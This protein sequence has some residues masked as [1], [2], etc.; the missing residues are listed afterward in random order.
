MSNSGMVINNL[1]PSQRALNII[2]KHLVNDISDNDSIAAAKVTVG[3]I[4][5]ILKPTISFIGDYQFIYYQ[6]V[7]EELDRYLK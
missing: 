4:L 3:E 6:Q 1:T 7:K 2:E 5:E